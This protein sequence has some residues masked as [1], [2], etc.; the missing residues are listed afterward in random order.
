MSHKNQ[1]KP[2]NS[3]NDTGSKSSATDPTK[4]N[5]DGNGDTQTGGH[6]DAW[7]GVVDSIESAEAKLESFLPD[8][9]EQWMSDQGIAGKPIL[10]AVVAAAVA[11]GIWKFS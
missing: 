9:W 1:E 4:S 2:M 6:R 11:Y 8:S 5:I 3:T 7:G 10:V